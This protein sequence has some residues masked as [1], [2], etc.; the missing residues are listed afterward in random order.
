MLFSVVIGT[1][2]VLLMTLGC[3]HE[4]NFEELIE[5]FHFG[6]WWVALGVAS[7]I[8]L[9][10]GGGYS[11]G[12]GN[13]YMRASFLLY[14]QG[15]TL[16]WEQSGC[17]GRTLFIISVCNNQLLDWIENEFIRVLDHIPGFASVWPKVTANLRA[18]KDKYL[19]APHP[20]LSNK[21][22]KRWDFS[23]ASLWNIVV[24]LMLMKFFVKIVNATAQSSSW[25]K[26]YERSHAFRPCRPHIKGLV[27]ALRE[28][29]KSHVS[30]AHMGMWGPQK[31]LQIFLCLWIQKPDGLYLKWVILVNKMIGRGISSN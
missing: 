28:P 6:L 30:H 10:S 29:L 23:F 13:G 7:S 25:D 11:M 17:H 8:G 24:R 1:L 16:V 18:M 20:V 26:P 3:L 12:F 4:K 22:G 21:Q 31:L 15:S 9:G 19:K 2:S 5:Y 27:K 14:L